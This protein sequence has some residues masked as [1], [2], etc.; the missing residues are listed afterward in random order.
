MNENWLEAQRIT[1]YQD[2][3]EGVL[4]WMD[5]TEIWGTI[6]TF[7]TSEGRRSDKRAEGIPEQDGQ[8]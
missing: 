4:Y 1:A 8:V 7:T 3:H 5:V 6:S 2:L